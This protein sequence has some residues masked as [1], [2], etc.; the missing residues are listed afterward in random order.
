MLYIADFTANRIDVM[1]LAD[2]TVHS[3]INV[4]PQP[5]SLSLSP[6]GQY[7]VI[8]H[9]GNA[10]APNPSNNALTVIHLADGTRQTFGLAYPP[11]G[12]AFGNDGL[13]LIATTTDFELFSPA[14]GALVEIETITALVAKTIPQ[15][16]GSFPPNIVAA[17]M[18]VNADSSVIIGL[19]DT[20]Q[21]GYSTATHQVNVLGY[22]ASPVLGPRTV[23]VAG[24]GSS[25]LAGWGLFLCGPG[26]GALTGTQ[27]ARPRGG[28]V[29][30]S[31]RYLEHRQ[32]CH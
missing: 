6:D 17:S 21:F 3:S 16:L 1:T 25:Y 19:T 28:I 11:L 27:F 7:L 14:T 20:L 32:P 30:E 5:G 29:P 9:F 12:V 22:T 24:D 26:G 15:P 2:H 18:N 4:N 31:F 13:A 23:S 8:V 10:A